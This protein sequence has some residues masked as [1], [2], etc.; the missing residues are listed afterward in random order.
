MN[1]GGQ[2]NIFF[3][4]SE[5][6]IW[7]D[8][9]KVL[10]GGIYLVIAA[11]FLNGI[12]SLFALSDF[13]D[14][15]EEWKTLSLR[16]LLKF[17]FRNF[18]SIAQNNLIHEQQ[19]EKS[20]GSFVV[21]A[22]IF[23]FFIQSNSLFYNY[24]GVHKEYIEYTSNGEEEIREEGAFILHKNDKEWL[25]EYANGL[26]EDHRLWAEE[27]PDFSLNTRNFLFVESGFIR[28][29]EPKSRDDQIHREGFWN[30]IRAIFIFS[31][32]IFV[33]TL[34]SFNFFL[35]LLGIKFYF[36]RKEAKKAIKPLQP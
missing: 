8:L 11:I 22:I 5:Y 23:F 18:F 4:L 17:F 16:E 7:Y 12:L 26:I 30:Y 28:G 14:K 10:L 20:Q 6:S 31:I 19:R 9:L 2:L 36:K 34:L 29:Y 33:I 24:T 1:T 15:D 3:G 25:A 27:D 13:D 35:L 32:E 21:F